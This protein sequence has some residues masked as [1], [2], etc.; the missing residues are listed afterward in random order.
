VIQHHLDAHGL[1]RKDLIRDYLSKST[2]DK[3]G[4]VFERTLTKIGDP[5]TSR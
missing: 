2:I 3:P 5:P 1:P 4:R